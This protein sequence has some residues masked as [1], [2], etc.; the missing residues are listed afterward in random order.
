MTH[1]DGC[2]CFVLVSWTCVV[3]QVPAL[4]LC[5]LQ[6]RLTHIEGSFVSF[7]QCTRSH[8]VQDNLVG[9]SLKI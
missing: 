1:Q 8:T 3:N 4:C 5:F 7:L 6:A 2:V 9:G